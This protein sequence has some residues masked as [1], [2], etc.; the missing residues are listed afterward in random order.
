MKECRVV[1]IPCRKILWGP[2]ERKHFGQLELEEMAATIKLHGVLEPIGVIMEGDRYLGLYGQR[3]CMASIV[4]GLELIPAIVRDKPSTDLEA[5]EIRLIENISRESLRPLDEA[6]ALS[7]FMKASGLSASEVAVRIGMKPGPLSKALRL[8][9][10]PEPIR[11]QIDAGVI[12]AAAGYELARVEN[13]QLQAELAAQVAGGSLSRDGLAGKIKTMKRSPQQSARVA[14]SRV[15]ARLGG[16]RSVTV[17]AGDLSVDS[18]IT[19]LEDLLSRCRAAR[20]KGVALGTLLKVLA[21]ESRRP[22]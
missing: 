9:E 5:S 16:S 14:Q 2:Q 21:D 6:S 3:R 22:A 18:M 4:A 19:T 8:L 13:P 12:S 20:K 15:T 11:K 17:C 10:L 7:Q 1:Q